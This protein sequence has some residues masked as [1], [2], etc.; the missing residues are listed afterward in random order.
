[1]QLPVTLAVLTLN[2][3]VACCFDIA[4]KI[5]DIFHIFGKEARSDARI[6]LRK[7]RVRCQIP[8]NSQW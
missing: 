1:M 8:A 6:K 4:A 3:V 2:T 7:R 5:F